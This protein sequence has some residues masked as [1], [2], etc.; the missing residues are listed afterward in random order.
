MVAIVGVA[1]GV[2]EAVIAAEEVV[3]SEADEEA[4]KAHM[5]RPTQY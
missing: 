1:A 2:S 5:D 3:A 4:S